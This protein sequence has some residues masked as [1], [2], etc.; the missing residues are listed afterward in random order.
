MKCYFF[1]SNLMSDKL[2]SGLGVMSF[3]IPDYGVVFR[4]RHQG[5]TYECEYA[6]A[7]ALA[8]FLELNSEHFKG[9]RL[10]LLS[11]SPIV[12]YQVNRRI[13]TVRRLVRLR[14]MLLYYKRKLSFELEWVPSNMNRAQMAADTSAVTRDTPKFNYDI[15]DETTRR[16]PLH[17]RRPNERIRIR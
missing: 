17:R 16:K 2:A 11:D 14:D 10:T 6:A 13:E 12:V 7:L 5:N 1:G 3:A 9:R 8:R 15:F 4:A